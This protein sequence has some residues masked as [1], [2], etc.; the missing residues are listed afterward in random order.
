MDLASTLDH[1]FRT[2]CK[3]VLGKEIGGLGE[4]G[5]WLSEYSKQPIVRKSALSGKPVYLE[6]RHYPKNGRF[7]HFNEVDFNRRFEPLS[8]NEIKDID[9]I[10]GALGERI[11]YTGSVILGNSKEVEES[12]NITDSF[13]IYKSNSIWKCKHLAHSSYSKE[14]SFLFGTHDTVGSEYM[15]RT[16]C[17]GGVRGNKRCFES[18]MISGSSDIHYS[19]Y[20]DGCS[21]CMFSFY[22]KGRRNLIGNTALPKEKYLVLKKALLEQMVS[23]LEAK[24][25]TMCFL[26]LFECS[27]EE[28]ADDAFAKFDTG[29]INVSFNETTKIL[30]GKELGDVDEYGGWLTGGLD[31]YDLKFVKSAVSGKPVPSAKE[32][33]G[34]TRGMR[35]VTLEELEEAS[36]KGVSIDDKDDLYAFMD[37]VRN[38]IGYCQIFNQNC[39]KVDNLLLCV[40]SH[41]SRKCAMPVFSKNIAYC[42]WPRESENA[43]GSSV[44]FNSSF[45]VRG[46]RSSNIARAF[47]VESCSN[48]SDLYFSHNVENGRD[49]MFCFNS[50]NIFR[51]IGNAEYSPQDYQKIKRSL[52]EQVSGDLMKTRSLKW[53][54]YG[55][56]DRC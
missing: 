15:I 56:G 5:G 37:K 32:Y 34:F 8:I 14:C 21:D 50:K 4:W 33:Y 43:F 2:T 28:S 26:D 40:K 12:T 29:E 52:L 53:N 1:G 49:C 9:S 51:A 45:V 16:T 47:E 20:L 54:I 11:A 30:L 24:H 3:I 44:I 36:R 23:E 10:A 35:H 39:D 17:A 42:F 38:Q 13:Y 41:N 31:F 46:I 27:K 48:S 19:V 7:L 6:S 25:K 22:Q 18:H 55:I